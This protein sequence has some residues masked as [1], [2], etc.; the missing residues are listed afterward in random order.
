MRESTDR[1][2]GDAMR[3]A[4]FATCLVDGL[5]PDVGKATI[6]LL[7][8]LGHE[9]DFP[10]QQTCCGQMHVNTGYPREALPLVRNHVDDVRRLRRHRRAE[11]VVRRLDPP[12]ARRRRRRGRRRARSPTTPRDGR[13]A[14]LRAVRVP[15]RRARRD[16]RRRL[17]PAPGDLPPDLP[18]AAAAAGRRPALPA[19]ARGARPRPGRAARR[20]VRAAASAA[21]SR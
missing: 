5:F 7:R 17:L 13:G 12:P 18:L 20:R 1:R 3:V 19:A 9:V 21:R 6:R 11:R 15:G 14:H 10:L 4:L 2:S 8:R 16:R